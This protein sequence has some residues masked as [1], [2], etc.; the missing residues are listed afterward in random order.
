MA[1]PAR[2]RLPIS[3]RPSS[4]LGQPRGSD[5]RQRR[6]RHRGHGRTPVPPAARAPDA[7][8]AR[9][10][11]ALYLRPT[12]RPTLRPAGRQGAGQPAEG[13]VTAPDRPILVLLR[14]LYYLRNLE[15]PIRLLAERGHR[16]AVVL[17]GR[18]RSAAGGDRRSESGPSSPT[19]TAALSSA[20]RSGGATSPVS[21]HRAPASGRDILRFYTPPFRHAKSSTAARS[22]RPAASPASSLPASATGTKRGTVPLM[23]FSTAS[24]PR[25][26]RIGPSRRASYRLIRPS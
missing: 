18:R 3:W 19:S 20:R 17:S 11:A 24:T 14:N 12:T 23:P 4:R 7:P 2:A 9:P 13:A 8:R 21:A 26:R 16:L 1:G 15:A 6:A 22:P 25:C 5:P 10:V